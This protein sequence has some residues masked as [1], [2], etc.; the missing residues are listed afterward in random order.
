MLVTSRKEVYIEEAL[1]NIIPP[2]SRI[3][4]QSHFVDDDIRTYVQ[5]RLLTDRAFK[6]WN[7]IP[8]VHD[9]IQE[10]LGRK[11]CGMYDNTYSSFRKPSLIMLRRFRWAACQL[12][13]LGRCITRGQI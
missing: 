10:I 4:L 7:K 9:Q 5:E 3:C 1:E 12:D 2:K 8:E 13:A 11:A 6:R